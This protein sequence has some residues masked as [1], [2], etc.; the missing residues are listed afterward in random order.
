M[1]DSHSGMDSPRHRAAAAGRLRRVPKVFVVNQSRARRALQRS[2]T[3]SP[4]APS[5]RSGEL[6]FAVTWLD[7]DK[8]GGKNGK[9][10]IR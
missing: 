5:I 3:R 9:M 6:S 10:T 1:W 4:A 8:E 7:K 2:R